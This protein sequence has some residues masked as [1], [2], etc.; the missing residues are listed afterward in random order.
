MD[1]QGLKKALQKKTEE[2]AKWNKAEVDA[3]GYET[4][5]LSAFKE[6]LAL[7]NRVDGCVE[8]EEEAKGKR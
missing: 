4:G 5:R 6:V 3:T 2:M 1:I 7:V 8:F